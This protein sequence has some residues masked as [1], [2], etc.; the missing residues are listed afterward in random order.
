MFVRGRVVE[1]VVI[2]YWTSR[3]IAAEIVLA[4][5]VVFSYCSRCSVAREDFGCGN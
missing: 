3:E 1:P 4:T 2:V 5:S